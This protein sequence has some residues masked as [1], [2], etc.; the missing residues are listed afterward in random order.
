MLFRSVS[1]GFNTWDQFSAKA[2]RRML[3]DEA[4]LKA[5]ISLPQGLFVSKSGQG[6]KT[7]IL[8]FE[9]GGKTDWTWFYKVSN[10]G[11]T[12]GTNRKE[13]KGNQLVE[14]LSL[15]HKYVKNG[16]QPPESK[17][18]F[19]IP[20]EWIK[21]LD[22]R[23]KNKIR[24]E[25]CATLTEKG[26]KERAKKEKEF[27]KK[28]KAKKITEAEK[29]K[30][31]KTFDNMLENR[32]QNEIAK[33]IDKAHNYSF[34]LANYKSTLSQSQIAE[35]KEALKH[36]QPN[37]ATTLDEVYKKLNNSKPQ[38]ALPY[39]LKLNPDNALEADIA[40]EYISNLEESVVAEQE[41]YEI[42][43]VLK[44]KNKY[45]FE[46]LEGKVEPKYIKIKKA[47]YDGDIDIVQKIS[48]KDGRIHFR[49]EN[50]TGMDLYQADKGDLVTSKINVHQGALALTD[51]KI[52]CSTH[53]QIY[54]ID[55]TQI[56]PDYLVLVL[57]SKQLQV[58]INEIKNGGIKNEQGAKF[59][60]T[61]KIPLPTIEEQNDIVSRIEKQKAIIEGADKIENNFEFNIPES[62][63]KRPLS[64]FIK[65]S[66][67]GL[68]IKLTDKGK[69]P[70]LR[71]NNLDLLGR[72]HL[73]DLKYTDIDLKDE[74]I[75]EYGDFI[76]NRTNSIDLVGKSSVVD[77]NMEG[78]WA[79]YLIRLKLNEALNPYYLKY[80]F[81]TKR[82]RDYFKRTCKPAGG[83]ANI[84]ANE[85]GVVPIDYFDPEI[86]NRI[87][88]ELDSQM[89]ILDGLQKMKLEAQKK[90]ETILADVWGAE[91]EEPKKSGG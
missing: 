42:K 30:E 58:R 90:I 44:S 59:L 19:C 60:M 45:P 4:Q 53:Y 48:F 91:T 20:A 50:I 86:Q 36:I 14:C 37:G 84:N 70:V 54:K 15:Y 7:S 21:S 13:Q 32:I 51:R 10:D 76:F 85:L 88:S 9:K 11:Y 61:L 49:D 29:Q 74:R 35:W 83:Q 18:Q 72:W 12:M 22:P 68:S 31:L 67:Y 63:E 2:L 1:E 34:N 24:K 82:Y 6:P 38:N 55:K 78:S 33:R 81:A 47:D 26:E 56:N 25:T 80:L 17:N 89:K 87:V 79:G 28:L 46:K 39:L 43:K 57:R 69:Y 5:V 16:E 3:L 66:L 64:S 40:R 23:I 75:L 27:D 8:L 77:F 73:E 62:E 52:V 41:L 71:M 65:D